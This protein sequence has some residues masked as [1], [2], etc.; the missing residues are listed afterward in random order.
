MATQIC[1]N[2]KADSFTWAIDED[3]S[4][5][6]IW[7]CSNCSYQVFENEYE[8]SE[9]SKCKSKTTSKLKDNLKEY[10]WCSNCNTSIIK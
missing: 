5:L 3:V 10:W 1:P 4:E 8:E 9:C 2:C 7:F 6:T